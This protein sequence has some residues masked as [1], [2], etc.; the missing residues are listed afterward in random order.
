MAINGKARFIRGIFFT[1]LSKM[2][3]VG[4]WQLIVRYPLNADSFRYI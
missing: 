2:V 4:F 1:V 3:Q